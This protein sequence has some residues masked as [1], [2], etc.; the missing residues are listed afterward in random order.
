MDQLYVFFIRNDVWIYF[1]CALGALWY[2]YEFLRG[3]RSLQRA[4]FNLERERATRKRNQSFLFLLF[5]VSVAAFVT[6]V[7]VRIQPTLSPTLL[8][9]PTPTPRAFV[10]PLTGTLEPTP[11]RR[12]LPSP[13]AILAPTATLRNPVT[14]ASA[15][16]PTVALVPT[17][18]V[19]AVRSGCVDGINITQPPSGSTVSGGVSLF[20]VATAPNFSNY[21]V[22]INGPET[23]NEW[24][25][26][27]P[28]AFTQPVAN[29]FL[30]GANLETW[31]TG[32]YQIRLTVRAGSNAPVG[33]CTIQIGLN[34]GFSLE[35]ETPTP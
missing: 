4:Y 10:T 12:P 18:P 11:T 30:A 13:T 31:E 14:P 7:N 33:Q 19:D 9:P 26:L 5:F 28:T 2:G 15:P 22:E 16:T 20:G 27:A 3:A 25:T 24:V 35:L 32:V 1:L 17:L 21:I 6:F 8:D 34:N 29:G 23:G